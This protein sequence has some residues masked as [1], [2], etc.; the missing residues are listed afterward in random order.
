MK[1]F[2]Y[3]FVLFLTACSHQNEQASFSWWEAPKRGLASVLDFFAPKNDLDN[4]LQ[5][6]E[7][8][9]KAAMEGI[10][11]G[12]YYRADL[13]KVGMSSPNSEN[14]QNIVNK[15]LKV[16]LD[17]IVVTSQ[18]PIE[19]KNKKKILNTIYSYFSA[20]ANIYALYAK[21]AQI[22]GNT[23]Q[24]DWD[25]LAHLHP[26]INKD[27]FLEI[28]EIINYP[29]KHLTYSQYVSPDLLKTWGLSPVY[30]KLS[31]DFNLIKKNVD[32]GSPNSEK[33]LNQ[34]TE[35]NA[36]KYY[37]ADLVQ[38]SLSGEEKAMIEYLVLSAPRNANE[39]ARLIQFT[40]VRENLINIWATRR[41][42]SANSGSLTVNQC[43]PG[44][45]SL[46]PGHGNLYG[47]DYTTDLWRADF[48]RNVVLESIIKAAEPIK[49]M[50]LGL[51]A[52]NNGSLE[53]QKSF[54]ND[55]VFDVYTA[56]DRPEQI[57]K[58]AAANVGWDYQEDLAEYR[59]FLNQD[60]FSRFIMAY[61]EDHWSIG[62]RS[63]TESTLDFDSLEAK[64]IA[65]KLAHDAYFWR[66]DAAIENIAFIVAYD[67]ENSEHQEAR[68]RIKRYLHQK[69]LSLQEKWVNKAAA[70]IEVELNKT[71]A[72]PAMLAK[73]KSDRLNKFKAVVSNNQLLRAK[74]VQDYLSGAWINEGR[75][76][77]VRA[78]DYAKKVVGA[79]SSV[80]ELKDGYAS[81]NPND[82][83][84][85]IDV[86][87]LIEIFSKQA[88]SFTNGGLGKSIAINPQMSALVRGFFAEVRAAFENNTAAYRKQMLDKLINGDLNHDYLS[89][90]LWKSLQQ[91]AFRYYE[92]YPF[93]Q[94]QYW[95][96][97][98][99]NKDVGPLEEYIRSQ[100]NSYMGDLSNASWVKSREM[101]VG[102]NQLDDKSYKDYEE[103][104]K[105]YNLED[106]MAYQ[107]QPNAFKGMQQLSDL[108]KTEKLSDELKK[109][110]DV[111]VVSY[112]PNATWIRRSPNQVMYEL[113]VSLGLREGLL[114]KKQ[115]SPDIDSE[116]TNKVQRILAQKYI[117]LGTLDD[118][119]LGLRLN[120]KDS[121]TQ[122]LAVMSKELYKVGTKRQ[123]E[124]KLNVWQSYFAKTQTAL[125]AALPDATTLKTFCEASANQLGQ[126]IK[127]EKL[128]EKTEHIRAAI[129]GSASQEQEQK[130]F[131]EFDKTLWKK[132]K[133][134]DYYM[135]TFIEPIVG[136]V[137]IVLM[138]VAI[139]G[140]GG[141]ALPAAV[142]L[143][144]VLIA[145]G[146]QA[147]FI[148][149]GLYRINYHVFERP[150]QLVASYNFISSSKSLGKELNIDKRIKVESYEEMDTKLSANTRDAWISGVSSLLFDGYAGFTIIRDIR[151][152]MGIQQARFARE[153]L[154]LHGFKP[155][156]KGKVQI[157]PLTSYMQ[158]QGRLK[159]LVSWVSDARKSQLTRM[160]IFQTISPTELQR[161]PA[162]SMFRKFEELAKNDEMVRSF[163]H[164][165]EGMD[166]VAA[167][168][169][170]FLKE[171]NVTIDA[172]SFKQLNESKSLKKV[173]AQLEKFSN[174]Y[175][176]KTLTGDEYI[177]H[178]RQEYQNIQVNMDDWV[179][180][181]ALKKILDKNDSKG[182]DDFIE[183]WKA[184]DAISSSAN[185]KKMVK[186]AQDVSTV[187]S[188]RATREANLKTIKFLEEAKGDLPIAAPDKVSGLSRVE[189]AFTA[190]IYYHEQVGTA[191]TLYGLVARQNMWQM[192]IGDP[193][194]GKILNYRPQVIDHVRD[195]VRRGIEVRDL[196][197]KSLITTKA[198]IK[199]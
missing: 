182:L 172:L 175:K 185:S 66:A 40:A 124:I 178:M 59:D 91:V 2:F 37:Y 10:P 13:Q 27:Y 166:P 100:K 86:D 188:W 161:A 52:T 48:Y 116:R 135:Q 136:I 83:L 186:A 24:Y 150:P 107:N 14:F 145:A 39:Y 147:P 28:K 176:A 165:Q 149:M 138:I 114:S 101:V 137:G 45:L 117:G 194:V 62:V 35:A 16:K 4:E 9:I 18:T 98:I 191:N 93:T 132:I 180:V 31:K 113:F 73:K 65:R 163:S 169:Q 74:Y 168:F 148:A 131:Q 109:Y 88:Y 118:A 105:K 63:I 151:K 199:K 174:E 30:E 129:L 189:E 69:L 5:E 111:Q 162:L 3:F 153:I 43:V 57:K 22:T 127:N 61:E 95:N 143:Q 110:F 89:N 119:L 87:T 195:Y 76:Y 96:F 184:I 34:L 42:S 144:S 171:F 128:Y 23:G 47:G 29:A 53:A 164:Y 198:V 20:Y 102:V 94:M 112:N 156:F 197:Q 50:S 152:L 56:K 38:M 41:L 46:Q 179:D 154:K 106:E 121:K 142:T 99:A 84:R 25:Q 130:N 85:I 15:L 196:T 72:A 6:I 140:S 67:N 139:V 7:A 157:D 78:L 103:K 36:K 190:W 133:P 26:V 90:M 21:M 123:P 120:P 80:I 183:K 49:K 122:M 71:L 1:F 68:E 108:Y 167:V 44:A 181:V 54:Y 158:K 17:L 126:D 177:A 97:E 159:G 173:V 79:P 170:Q 104:L 32:P 115:F 64:S 58:F 8:T 141:V 187:A 60:D 55:L 155:G 92:K 70:L 51:V 12:V 77:V 125:Q 160:P 192:M 134:F 11:A 193:I 81:I 19:S 75:P 33:V 146:I 82:R